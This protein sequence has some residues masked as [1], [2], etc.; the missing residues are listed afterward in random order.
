MPHSGTPY[1][2]IGMSTANKHQFPHVDFGFL[3]WR[4]APSF[5]IAPR[6]PAINLNNFQSV[7]TIPT[8]SKDIDDSAV[9]VT[10]AEASRAFSLGR[11]HQA[12]GNLS[13][14]VSEFFRAIDLF[15]QLKDKHSLRILEALTFV[16]DIYRDQD[17]LPEY[18]GTCQQLLAWKKEIFGEISPSS[19]QST[20]ELA[21]AFLETSMYSEAEALF[22][23]ALAGF[24]T[25]GMNEQYLHCQRFL[26][27]SLRYQGQYTEAETRLVFV[28]AWCLQRGSKDLMVLVITS[29]EIIY[30][31]QGPSRS[32]L[33]ARS[34][35]VLLLLW[36]QVSDIKDHRNGTFPEETL[37][38]IADL[39]SGYSSLWHLELAQMLYMPLIIQFGRSKRK[40]RAEK[41]HAYH[42]YAAH[43]R[44][45]G[46]PKDAA[47][48]LRIYVKKGRGC[49]S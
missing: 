6:G 32:M 13:E 4:D 11:S 19:L 30:F 17:L 3:K 10:L 36:D 39:A 8:I 24:E 43:C 12:T 45:Q 14:A 34:S 47:R 49:E 26:G 37:L 20:F 29:L 23:E 25:L 9:S 31:K 27:E 44:R 33:A 35:M 5:P 22:R 48:F 16:T 41:A 2:E 38:A 18:I 15:K 7:W 40:R 42:E 1:A 21:K 28:L 46:R